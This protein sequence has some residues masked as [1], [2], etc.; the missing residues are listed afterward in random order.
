[1]LGVVCCDR[2]SPPKLCFSVN[3]RKALPIF[4]NSHFIFLLP[5]FSFNPTFDLVTSS[6]ILFY[7]C[8]RF[9]L[10][11]NKHP[12]AWASDSY[13]KGE[14]REWRDGSALKSAC[15]S[16]REPEFRS[17]HHVR[18]S[19]H[20]PVSPAPGNLIPSSDSCGR[21]RSCAYV[22]TNTCAL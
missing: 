14:T 22:C 4:V 13:R 8:A 18:L 7:G 9:S 1:M 5:L 10:H 12:R 2:G 19:P 21:V 17:Q 6:V 11:G 3:P 15:C 20:L 16:R